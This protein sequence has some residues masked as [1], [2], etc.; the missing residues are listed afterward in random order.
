MTP[1]A[2]IPKVVRRL[3][4]WVVFDGENPCEEEVED[5]GD[6]ECGQVSVGRGGHAWPRQHHYSQQVAKQTD[7]AEHRLYDTVNPQA[8]GFSEEYRRAVGGG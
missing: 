1:I 8:S 7:H 3:V 2:P 6:G 5:V 4:I